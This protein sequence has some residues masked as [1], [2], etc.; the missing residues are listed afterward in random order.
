MSDYKLTF[1]LKQHTPII[2]FQHEQH[3]ATLRA[4][5][6]K[7]KLDK[8]I[9]MKIGGEADNLLTDEEAKYNKGYEVAKAKKWLVGKGEHPALDYK[10]KI[11]TNEKKWVDYYIEQPKIKDG[12]FI[13]KQNQDGTYSTQTNPYPLYFGNMGMDYNEDDKIKKFEFC[14]EVIELEIHCFERKLKDKILEYL[15]DFLNSENFGS[16][17]GKGFGCFSL[18]AT[19]ENYKVFNEK[20]FDY[21]FEIKTGG[22]K[23]IEQKF[24]NIFDQIDLFYRALRSGINQKMPVYELLNGGKHIKKDANGLNEF[25]DIFYFKSLLF[26]YFKNINVQWE[27]KTIKEEFFLNDQ[28]KK[29]KKRNGDEEKVLA[30]YG[31]K[32]QRT[33][34]S[35][36]DV[37]F[38]SNSNKQLVKDLLGLS[39][40][41]SWLS[42]HNSITK[43]EAKDDYSGRK[44][45]K[46]KKED[47]IQ[48]FKSPIFFKVIET[49]KK[50]EFTIYIK[51]NA[52]IPVAGKWFIIEEKYGKSFPLQIPTNFDL[53]SF[54]DF[55]LD[56]S[57][58]D[59]STHVEE[60]F[61]TGNKYYEILNNIFISIQKI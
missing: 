61:H 9:L 22:I 57:K 30:Y 27:K 4:S 16:R 34:R 50:G 40:Q 33:I 11:V 7:P 15:S 26:L 8:F 25:E 20:L 54:F 13:Q 55:I 28:Y 38:Y 18:D 39:S 5:E 56:K 52:D 42:Y 31:L 21:K 44:V 3:G 45:R 19:D 10:V 24:R 12:E 59:I 1:K 47:Q 17:Q 35:S 37:L 49:D 43:T 53:R 36:A 2:H 32:T 23:D 51:L 60:K 46:D 14:N 6:L 29:I 48:R 58:F 41:E